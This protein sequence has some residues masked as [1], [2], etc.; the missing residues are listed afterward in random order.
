M[1]T[2]TQILCQ[3]VWGTKR[4]EK[5]LDKKNREEL[6]KYIRGLCEKKKCLAYQINGVEDHIHIVVD[7]HPSVAVS[8]LV[9]DIKLATTQWIKKEKVFPRFSGWQAGFGAFTYSIKEKERVVNYVKNQ[10]AHHA[11]RSFLEEYIEFL[12]THEVCYDPQYVP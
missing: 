12:E 4:R 5:T 2:Y 8:D 11:Y 6:F 7:V 1:S 3:L 9:K 10:E